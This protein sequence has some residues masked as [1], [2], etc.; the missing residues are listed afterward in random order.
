[1]KK[2]FFILTAMITFCF[3]CSICFFAC[4][5][6][7][8]AESI[9]FIYNDGSPLTEITIFRGNYSYV[10]QYLSITPENATGYTLQWSSSSYDKVSISF[11]KLYEVRIDALEYTEEPVTITC[12]IKDTDIRASF[13]VNVTDGELQNIIVDSSIANTTFYEGQT[14]DKNSLIVWGYFQNGQQH[15]LNNDELD[16]EV[17]NPLKI[18]SVLKIKYENFEITQ[19]L[20]VVEDSVVSLNIEN[21]P[22]RLNYTIGEHFDP[23]GLVV[24]GTFASG[25]NEIINDYTFENRPFAYDDNSIVISYNDYNISI[26]LNISATTTVSSF[27]QL[28]EAVNN[29]NVGDSICISGKEYSNVSTL[30]IPISKNLTIFGSNENGQYTKIKS[31]SSSAIKLINDSLNSLNKGLTIANLDLYSSGDVISFDDENSLSNINGLNLVIENIIFNVYEGFSAINFS[32]SDK[33]SSS[34]ISSLSITIENCTF[35][36]ENN[37]LAVTFSNVLN[38]NIYI[39]NSSSVSRENIS[40]IDC[41]GVVIEIDGNLSA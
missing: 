11:T 13:L 16:V 3:L 41:Q 22:K 36:M 39:T 10:H 38:S 31:S 29:A 35:A 20:N 40:I 9:S 19:Q 27:N 24:R 17:D 18:G 26:P 2:K 8:A 6:T 14:F 30:F 32:T 4:G 15:L 1:M 21:Y 25:K 7:I 23:E 37:A 5:N 34:Q 28:Q 12:Q 33:F